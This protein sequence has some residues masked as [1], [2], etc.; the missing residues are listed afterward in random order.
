LG[1]N[2][3][4]A[5]ARDSRHAAEDAL[6]GRL[7]R[8]QEAVLCPLRMHAISADGAAADA[9]VFNEVSLLR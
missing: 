8:A 9:P 1:G 4:A 3:L 2:A 7:A 5:C 6:P